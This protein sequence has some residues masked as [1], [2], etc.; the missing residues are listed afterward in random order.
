[1]IAAAAPTW[2]KKE[3]AFSRETN[4]KPI[5][6]ALLF[7]L[8]KGNREEKILDF[9]FSSF[10]SHHFAN[11]NCVIF[12]CEEKEKTQK[13]KVNF[14]GA[15]RACVVL[16]KKEKAKGLLL[17]RCYRFIAKTQRRET[18]FSS[19][20]WNETLICQCCTQQQ[21]EN[22]CSSRQIHHHKKKAGRRP[23]ADK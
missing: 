11:V 18:F 13:S 8:Y 12:S 22:F 23:L 5:T 4:F 20:I 21:K 2:K 6:Q 7:F 16:E 17:L 15:V 19:R 9:L 10:S 14:C 3:R 1:M